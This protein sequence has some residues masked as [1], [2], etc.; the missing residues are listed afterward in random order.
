MKDNIVE[1]HIAKIFSPWAGGRYPSDS[2]YSGERFRN[3]YLIP[4][5]VDSSVTKVIVSLIGTIGLGSS[6]K[7]ELFGGAVRA[8]ITKDILK[9]KL[10]IESKYPTDEIEIWKYIEDAHKELKENI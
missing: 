9:T 1:L 3:E 10:Q 8:G 2:E 7:E 4:N 6:F 5:L